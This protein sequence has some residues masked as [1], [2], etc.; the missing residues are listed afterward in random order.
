MGL[1]ASTQFVFGGD[2]FLPLQD[3]LL[4]L[5]VLFLNLASI[6]DDDSG[7][8]EGYDYIFD[9]MAQFELLTG[10]GALDEGASTITQLTH[11][12]VSPVPEAAVVESCYA[13]SP[14][15]L[16]VIDEDRLFLLVKQTREVWYLFQVLDVT[17]SIY[18][19]RSL[20]VVAAGKYMLVHLSSF[21]ALSN[22]YGEFLAGCCINHMH[23]A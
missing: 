17:R 4:L 21:L 16:E 23:L 11:V 6:L 5:L 22:Y 7:R 2:Q 1:S 8:I 12:I 18:A 13:V 10:V 15:T 20:E 9:I 14:A 19:Q 3:S